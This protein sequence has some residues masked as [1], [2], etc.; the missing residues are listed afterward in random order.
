MV[1]CKEREEEADR[2]ERADTSSGGFLMDEDFD[3]LL[4]EPSE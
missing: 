4:P 3:L 2:R 1:L